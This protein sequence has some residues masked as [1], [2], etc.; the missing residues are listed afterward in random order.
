MKRLLSCA[1]V[2]FLLS[3]LCIAAASAETRSVFLRE[4]FNDLENW[5]PLFFPK[6]KQHSRYTIVKDGPD[7][8]LKAESNASASGIIYKKE[9]SVYDYPKVRWR[10]KVSNIYAKG[11]ERSKSGDDYPIRIYIIFKYDPDAAAF[12]QMIKYGLAK[13]IYGEYP[14]HS[15]LNY[16]WANRK[17]AERIITNAYADEAKMILLEAGPEKAGRWLEEEIDIL[18]DYQK[19]FGTKPPALASIA[20]MNDSDNTGESSESFVDYIEVFR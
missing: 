6:I 17:H 2:L 18:D 16:I 8:L 9:F 7:S 3:V 4:D 13:R 1:V 14:P 10:W 11:D 12:G 15:S 5:R 20:I 19:A